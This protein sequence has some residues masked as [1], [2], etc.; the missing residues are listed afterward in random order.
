MVSTT[1]AAREILKT[2]DLIFCNRPKSR[3]PYRFFNG[4]RDVAFSPYGEHWRKMK[5]I[6]I[7][8]LLSNKKVEANRKLREEEV[9]FI[10][11]EIKGSYPSVVN[12]SE[13]MNTQTYDLICRATFGRKYSSTDEGGLNFK[14][15][16]D[17]VMVLLGVFAVGDYM[18]WLG[19]MDRV[20]GLDDRIERTAKRLDEL[21]DKVVQEHQ[22]H[23]R[24]KKNIN[25]ET[26][27]LQTLL[28]YQRENIDAISI[29]D[30][31]AVV[32]DMFAAGTDTT[33]TLLEWTI[34][35]LIRHPRVMKELQEEVRKIVGG[36]GC[37]VKVSEDDLE[38]LTYLKA[39]I[40]ESLRLH[41]P[42]PLLV[43][44][45]LLQDTKINGF[46]IAAGTRVFINAWAIHRDPTYW[47][48]P[49][50]FRP[51]RF[52][53]STT[54]FNFKGQDNFQYTPFGGGRRI[55]PGIS[56]AMVN[57]EL[58]LAN[59]IYEFDWKMPSGCGDL[60]MAESLGI[61]VHKQDP[62]M[63]I[64]TSYSC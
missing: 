42:A 45:E 33:Y 23:L 61:T 47:E 59:L 13:I 20:K 60:N 4:S 2:N 56:F 35:E 43:Y 36:K 27:F 14:E 62:L 1:E 49:L 5:G 6:C 30:V 10:V 12:L 34:A 51:E 53:N 31:K 55:C 15:L 50:E 19:W 11:E 24:A 7:T 52:L 18:P 54:S 41:P 37:M 38:Q 39:V 32:L 25:E 44:R 58:L 29:D 48:E 9:A 64:A 17:E 26:Y 63:L 28:E 21:L 22:N 40:K 57:A 8:H 46:D 3:V 16:L